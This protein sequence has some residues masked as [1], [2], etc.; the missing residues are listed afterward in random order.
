MRFK[1]SHAAVKH[2]EWHVLISEVWDMPACIS[3][4]QVS[5]KRVVLAAK[6]S[7]SFLSD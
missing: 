7:A 5:Q 1:S 6:D 4:L 2:V 3:D